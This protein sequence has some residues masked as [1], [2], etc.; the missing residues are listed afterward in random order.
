M[1][2]DNSIGSVTGTTSKIV[3]PTQTTTYTL[4]ATNSA[5]SFTAKATVTVTAK[6]G[7]QPPTTPALVSAVA[8]S[9]SEVDLTW[10]A[11][12]DS[13]GVTGYQILR[14][15]T[16]LTSV[17]GSTLTYADTSAAAATTYTYAVKAF[18][19]AANLSAA[20]NSMQVTTP[21]ALSQASCAA[22]GNGVFTGCYYSNT[23]LSG[24][25]VL[26]R[27]DPKINFDW[28]N[29]S[30]ASS[31]P[32]DDFSVQWQG[33]F[34]FA[35]GNYKFIAVTSDGMKIYIDGVLVLNRW[36]DQPPYEYVIPLTLSQGNHLIVVDYY[37]R[38]GGSE[39]VL[40]WQLE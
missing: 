8:R 29:G 38:T 15:G 13:V 22:P 34:T 3:T 16:L 28:R 33:N 14:N 25:P 5:G 9:S 31:I 30:P 39:A 1:A 12:T 27:T 35:Q 40:T 7:T 26:V 24:T 11:S 10:T 19:A 18:D 37:E 17:S 2:I 4:T 36:Y 32:A 21:P 20:S 6:T 23:T